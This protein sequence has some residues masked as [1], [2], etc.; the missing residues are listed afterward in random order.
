MIEHLVEQIRMAYASR[1]LDAICENLCRFAPPAS[2]AQARSIVEAEISRIRT[3]RDPPGLVDPSIG[4]WYLGPSAEDIFWPLLKNRLAESGWDETAVNGLDTETTRIISL[5][6]HPGVGAFKRRG[7]V[8]GYVQSG[9]TANFTGVIS[10]AADAGY[11]LFIV[12]SGV[13]NKLRRQTQLRFDSDLRNL[14]NE[15]WITLTDDN[16]DF[17]RQTAG[18]VDA[19]LT[20]YTQHKTVCVVKKIPMRLTLLADWLSSARPEVLKN[21]PV[22]IIDDEADEASINT[23]RTQ[24]MRSRANRQICRVVG[25]LPKVAYI[26]YTATPF[27]N[28]FIDPADDEDLYP[29]DFIID[30]PRKSSYFGAERIFGRAELSPDEAERDKSCLDVVRIIEGKEVDRLRPTRANRASF[31]VDLNQLPIL[32]RAARWFWL[33]T[34]CRRIRSG[35]SDAT[36]HS[37]MLIHSSQMAAVHNAF[38]GPLE[39]FR[40]ATLAALEAGDEGAEN[41]FKA[42]WEEEIGRVRAEELGLN[43]VPFDELRGA[44]QK[45]VADTRIVIENYLANPD[46]RLAYGDDPVTVIVVGGAILA[47]GLTLEGLVTSLFV[48]SASAY[49]ALLQMGRWFGYRRGYEDLPRIFMSS[50][51]KSQFYDLATVEEELRRD[52]ARYEREGLTPLDFAPRIRT[53]PSLMIT[54]R[55]KMQNAKRCSISYDEKRIQTTIFKHRDKDWLK[56]NADAAM[57]LVKGGIE[58]G[59][60]VEQTAG[61]ML[62]RNVGVERIRSFLGSYAASDRHEMFR[63]DVLGNY[64]SAEIKAGSLLTWNVVIM[65]HRSSA[66]G[67]LDLG[68]EEPV[69]LIRRSRIKDLGGDEFANIKAL[70]SEP[71]VCADIVTVERTMTREEM[72]ALRNAQAPGIGLLLLYPIAKHSPREPGSTDRADLVAEMDVIGLGLVFP[73][74]ARKTGGV[75]YMTADLSGV[76]QEEPELPIEVI[77]E[78]AQ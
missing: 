24:G 33:A 5:L 1:S 60:A 51:L 75:D 17:S 7:L 31:S 36:F 40:D 8:V 69:N 48:R 6:E 19:F 65:G 45:V 58:D 73:K 18:N 50:D 67:R 35:S 34:A 23:A 52:I 41:A 37:S 22:L 46:D 27:A 4:G 57:S 3:L 44:L 47:R 11:R 10:K 61:R 70:M 38:R 28:V 20:Q 13:T 68:L 25:L 53:H 14:L 49:D 59:A 15:R 39:A 55:L 76:E 77:E 72:F 2:V 74:T 62:L 71:D 16:N 26:G 9:K 42:L 32:Q 66:L 29:R 78:G 64:I 43:P 12:M 56:Q 21:C 63:Q 54:S 30:L